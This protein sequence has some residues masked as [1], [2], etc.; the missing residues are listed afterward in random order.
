MKKP[1]K[2]VSRTPVPQRAPK[3]IKKK[4]KLSPIKFLKTATNL[5]QCPFPSLPE[6]VIV[7]RSNSGKSSL[8]NAIWGASTARVSSR[9]GR[10][11]YLNFFEVGN[12][13]RLV[14]TPGYGFSKGVDR[15]VGFKAIEE[16][17][18]KR[19]RLEL[20]VLVM[21]VR[22][23]WSEQEALL[24]DYISSRGLKW[25]LAANKVDKLNRQEMTQRS[26]AL[27]EDSGAES[28]YFISAFKGTEVKSLEK[29]IFQTIQ[30][31]K[32]K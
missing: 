2:K 24:I 27:V 13:Y 5:K 12:R 17:L 21:D 26:K 16:Y 30:N 3:L 25:V 29:F 32:K 1:K 20:L 22:R 15:E 9:P 11:A 7:G 19:D 31:S 14:D 28:F 10:T 6:V 18:T 23:E 8:I 4:L